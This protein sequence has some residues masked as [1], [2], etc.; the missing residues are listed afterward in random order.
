MS[1][2]RA[3]FA[4]RFA[5][6][7]WPD[8]VKDHR[9][10]GE[11]DQNADEAVADFIK[12]GVGCVA[13]EHAEEKSERDLKTG[14]ADPFAPGCDP[15]GNCANCGNEHNQRRDRFHVRNKKYDG[16]NREPAANHAADES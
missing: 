8:I 12:I 3:S 13:L 5:R 6:A 4:V 2:F 16:E 14:V 9:G 11:A 7:F 10:N 1:P 15:A